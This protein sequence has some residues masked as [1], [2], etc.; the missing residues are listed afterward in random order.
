M[1]WL[2]RLRL[3]LIFISTNLVR[4]LNLYEK[5]KFNKDDAYNVIFLDLYEI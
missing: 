2:L 5:D 4:T 3:D 1:K